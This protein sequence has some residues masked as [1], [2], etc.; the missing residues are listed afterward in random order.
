MRQIKEWQILPDQRKRSSFYPVGDVGLRL[1]CC[2]FFFLFQKRICCFSMKLI[3]RQGKPLTIYLSVSLSNLT[4]NCPYNL[5][6]CFQGHGGSTV[7]AVMTIQNTN[8]TISSQKF[9][10]EYLWCPR[11]LLIIFINIV[12]CSKN[13]I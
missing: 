6:S 13:T 7:R 1:S 9:K 3:L 10:C 11:L 5:N 8:I 12:Q 2:C 4:D